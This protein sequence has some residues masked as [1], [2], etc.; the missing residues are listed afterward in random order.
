MEEAVQGGEGSKSGETGDGGRDQLSEVGGRGTKEAMSKGVSAIKME[1]DSSGS[2]RE[3]S[4]D[5]GVLGSFSKKMRKKDYA[6]K[7]SLHQ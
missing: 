7:L 5:R 2:L 6:E 3:V 1:E 4:W